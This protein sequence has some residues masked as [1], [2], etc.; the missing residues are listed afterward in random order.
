VRTRAMAQ[1]K[2]LLKGD[3]YKDIIVSSLQFLVE[4]K[5]VKVFSFVIMPN[6]YS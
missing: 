6:C 4:N 2:P 5:R 1:G 3:K